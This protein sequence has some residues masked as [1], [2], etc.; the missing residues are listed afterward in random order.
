MK[1]LIM[2]L[3]LITNMVYSQIPKNLLESDTDCSSY[4][5]DLINDY[6]KTKNLNPLKIDTSLNKACIHHCDYMSV[7]DNS[8]HI[9]NNR[10]SSN[11]IESI[12]YPLERIE[13]YGGSRGNSVSENCLNIG[14][15]IFNDSINKKLS[16]LWKSNISK[17]IIDPKIAARCVL[18]KWIESS[19]HN[20]VL[21][22]K[23]A[24]FSG[25]YQK[26]YI[27]K[28]GKYRITSNLL[29]TNR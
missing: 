11:I 21:L 26:V 28:Y 15:M 3:F 8:T 29:I 10:D 13:F 24:T 27:N 22:D 2:I 18:N 19:Y 7:Y 6:R 9:E 25:V 4:L 16:E 17:N 20:L 1:I 14:P 23:E 5:L 12:P